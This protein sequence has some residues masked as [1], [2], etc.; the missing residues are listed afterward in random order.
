MRYT[1]G[2]GFDRAPRILYRV[3]VGCVDLLG[4]KYASHGV[5]A[6]VENFSSCQRI[7]IWIFPIMN[8]FCCQ[9]Y[10][11]LHADPLVDTCTCLRHPIL[12]RIKSHILTVSHTSQM[13]YDQFRIRYILDQNKST[14][15]YKTT[16]R[17]TECRPPR[18]SSVVYP[19]MEG[20]ESKVF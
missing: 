4:W 16:Y 17:Q 20:T 7:M 5:Y 6:R 11:F 15:V 19:T 2:A 14:I 1:G 18:Q 12:Y 9:S 8:L 13:K 3:C 10:G